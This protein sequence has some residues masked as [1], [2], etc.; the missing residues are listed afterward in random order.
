MTEKFEGFITLH[1]N[2]ILDWCG[3]EDIRRYIL[4]EYNRSNIIGKQE[5]DAV[6]GIQ[7]VVA[8]KSMNIQQLFKVY[9]HDTQCNGTIQELLEYAY[10]HR[11]IPYLV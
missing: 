11:H 5:N 2:L 6:E 7:N 3:Y 4:Y 10:A 1:R 8:Q 9:C